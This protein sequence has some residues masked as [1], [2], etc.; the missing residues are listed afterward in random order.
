MGGNEVE[1]G[2]ASRSG[3]T[4]CATDLDLYLHPLLEDPPTPAT[5]R[6]DV[7]EEYQAL[8]ARAR[9]ACSACALLVECMY[10]AVVQ[11]DVSGY[12]GCTTPAERVRMRELLTVEVGAEEL[13]QYAGTRASRQPVNHD[14]VVRM[15]AQHPDDSLET[16]AGRLGCSLS[17]VKRHLRR[18]RTER[19]AGRPKVE[20]PSVDAVLDAFDEVVEIREPSGAS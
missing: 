3:V 5:A 18:A 20:L 7:W 4:A 19:A 8:V 15:R 1:R 2:S 6:P 10:K 12:V 14:D 11:T 16:I 13:D 9:R 17:T